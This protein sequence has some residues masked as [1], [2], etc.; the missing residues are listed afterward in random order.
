MEGV[1]SAEHFE[2]DLSVLV[3]IPDRPSQL[4][5]PTEH[6]GPCDQ[7]T[8]DAWGQS[9]EL[10]V[11]ERGESI[12]IGERVERPLDLYWSIRASKSPMI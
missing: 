3:A 5:M 6:I 1:G 8:G 11:Q 12:E 4:R 2:D 7:L 10:D 9:W